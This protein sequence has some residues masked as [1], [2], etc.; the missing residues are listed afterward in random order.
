MYF[1]KDVS[2]SLN[3]PVLVLNF[4]FLFFIFT[5]LGK[6]LGGRHKHDA[7]AAAQTYV[8]NEKSA[9]QQNSKY[10][11]TQETLLSFPS[12]AEVRDIG[13]VFA[14]TFLLHNMSFRL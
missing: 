7:L 1:F 6:L 11:M 3:S 4:H 9:A 10:T 13:G 2:F 14:K 12:S 8:R 5:Q